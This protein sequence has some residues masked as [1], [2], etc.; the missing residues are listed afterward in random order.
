MET[1]QVFFPCVFLW[2]N[3]I[4]AF[5]HKSIQNSYGFCNHC[6]KGETA[7]HSLVVATIRNRAASD[8]PQKKSTTRGKFIQGEVEHQLYIFKNCWSTFVISDTKSLVKITG[9]SEL[10]TTWWKFRKLNVFNFVG[11]RDSLTVNTSQKYEAWQTFGLQR[12]T[13]SCSVNRC[14][15]PSL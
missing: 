5:R 12:Q 13:I 10:R 7:L 8:S 2:L 11:A 9:S 14:Y 1:V 15:L 4:T 6:L 3:R